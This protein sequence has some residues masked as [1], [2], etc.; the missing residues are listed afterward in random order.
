[1]ENKNVRILKSGKKVNVNWKPDKK[2]FYAVMNGSIPLRRLPP[3][4]MKAIIDS[5]WEALE[6]DLKKEIKLEKVDK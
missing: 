2:T 6:K 4:K 1:M 3:N 5:D